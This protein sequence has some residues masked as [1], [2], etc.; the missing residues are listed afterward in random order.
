MILSRKIAFA[1]EEI[2]QSSSKLSHQRE[3]GE[4]LQKKQGGS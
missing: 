3:G 1:P 4:S 2:L